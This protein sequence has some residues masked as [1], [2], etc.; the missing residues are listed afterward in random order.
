MKDN[1]KKNDWIALLELLNS[2]PYDVL[3]YIL[4]TKGD[5]ECIADKCSNVF[6]GTAITKELENS[7]TPPLEDSGNRTEFASGAVRDMHEGKGRFDLMPLEIISGIMKS[8]NSTHM[9][10]YDCDI[11]ELV[12]N[13]RQEGNTNNLYAAISIFICELIKGDIIN[14]EWEFLLL[15]AKHYENGAIKY[16]E[17]NWQKGIPVNSCID[18]ALRHYTKF[19][20]GMTDEPHYVAFVWNLITAIYMVDELNDTSF[21][22][23]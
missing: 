20:A 14:N 7:A 13:F 1:Y 19:K 10:N 23:R 9:E 21:S 22:C 17:N 6:D 5:K 15:L 3:V 11:F 2:L 12:H 4:E 16:G 8:F 18:S